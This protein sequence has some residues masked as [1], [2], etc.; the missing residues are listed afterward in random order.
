MSLRA[1]ILVYLVVVHVALGCIAVWALLDRPVLLLIFEVAFVTSTIVGYRLLQSFFVPLQLIRTGAEL[2]REQDFTTHFREVGQ[3]EMD[4]LVRIYNRMVDRLREE[5]LRLEEQNLFL[6]QVLSASP[7]GVLT[8]DHDGNLSGVN[9]CAARLLGEPAETWIGKPV[10]ELPEPF[11]AALSGLGDGTSTVLSLRGG[12][13]RLKCGRASFYDRGFPRAFFLLEELTEELHASEKAAYDKLIR[14]M[15]HEVNN[16]VGAV[17]S[18]LESLQGYGK[19]LPQTERE[20][21]D[22]AIVAA[23]TRLLHLNSFMNALADVVRIP[24]PERRPC[25]LR[26]LLGDMAL[27]LRPELERRGIELVWTPPRSFPLVDVDKNQ[28]EQVLVNVL[29]NSIEAIGRDGRITVSLSNAGRRPCLAIRDTGPGIV[30]EARDHLFTPFFTTKPR[31]QGI[32]LTLTRE[33]LTQ[34]GFDFDLRNVEGGGTEF[35][36]RFGAP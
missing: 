25:D 33:V 3:S 7:I 28:I 29:R 26:E 23:V 22:H 17:R 24:P 4:Q 35:R 30:A 18:L 21:Y 32:G 6:E 27:L 1:K 34:H 36:I 13:R 9:P 8:L 11:G 31:G 5:R 2:M 19:V 20:E 12:G 10:S 14:M 16:S 15:S